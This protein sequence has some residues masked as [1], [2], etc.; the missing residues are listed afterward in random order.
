MKFTLKD[1]QSDA[2]SDVLR[3]LGKARRYFHLEE[4]RTAFS[5][6]AVTGAGK[7][8]MAAAVIESLFGGS[9]TFDFAPDP[10]AV[11]LWFS[12]DPSL[13]EQTRFRLLEAS[14]R[15][16]HSNLVAVQSTFNA[17][18]F[19]PG[20]VY[21]LNTQKLGKKSLLVRGHDEDEDARRLPAMSTAARPDLRSYTIWDTITNT[22]EDRNLTLYLVLDE[23]HRG[24]GTTNERE[25]STIVQRL[26]NG[27]GE[28]PPIPVVWGISATVER[29]DE[30]MKGV[31]GRATLPG[32]QVDSARVQQSGL[33]KDDIILDIPAEAG[34]FDTV[35]L[36]RATRKI[37][38][39]TDA[40]AKYA[41]E[42]GELDP[43]VPLLILQSPNTPSAE[44]LR[45]ALDLIFA[46]WEDLPP[47]AV[48]HVFGDHVT[49]HFGP[50]TVPYIAPERVQDAKHVRVL[51][52]KDAISTGWD[53]PRAEV[54]VSF[55]P[56]QDKTHIT[57]LLGRMVRA[58][59]A[60]RIPGDDRL[61]SV[62]C[63]LPFFDRKTATS[64]ATILMNSGNGEDGGG[65]GTGGGDGRR[66]LF[67]PVEMKPNPDLSKEVWECFDA[68]PSQS[69]PKRAAKPIKRLTALA[70]ALADDE[71]LP[72][73]GK[74]A[75]Q[76]LHAV[77]DGLAVRYENEVDA[78]TADVKTVEGE[79][80][81]GHLGG[82]VDY[83]AF[84]E[85]A[86]DRVIAD[87][88][89]A[90]E[91]V[92]SADV[93][94]TYA[95]HLAAAGNTDNDDEALRDA[96]VRVA[97][98]ALVPDIK[99]ALEAEA[100]KLASSWLAKYRVPIKGLSDERQAL[101]NELL[102]MSTEPQQVLLARPKVRQEETKERD[103]DGN[104][105]P[106][107]TRTKHLLCAEDG[108]FPVGSLN[109]W[110]LDVLGAELER[111]GTTAWYRNPARASQDSLA[112][113]YRDG[114]GAWKAMRPDFIFFSE[115]ASGEIG[116]SIVDPHGHHLGD[117]LPKLQGLAAFAA[118]F[119][120]AFLRID[121]IA[122][123]KGSLRVLDLTI[124]SV[125]KGVAEAAD[126]EALYSGSHAKD[127]H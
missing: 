34:R 103:K 12:D 32:V 44:M 49:M 94:L 81:R 38:E 41:A 43:V 120:G 107:P 64:V 1:Y 100:D 17:E 62:E 2:V 67:H 56:A 93:A 124:E 15:I 59:L 39:S 104:E 61:N 79:T 101:Y 71:L 88:Y 83:S 28:V 14:D 117:A 85:A 10:G 106:L 52:A 122:K 9:D 26:I 51:F 4:D 40:W 19:T 13:N 22:V 3:N 11:V 70:Q 123:V 98:L 45:R 86:D 90:A 114:K 105:T 66:V 54:L 112:V 55:R 99:Q 72:D 111:T 68:L 92:F 57:Q 102:A 37:V 127:Y 78:A 5:L 110:E 18:K 31:K 65:G 48:A 25:K 73:A 109:A 69:L 42:Q 16:G 46:E 118:K 6:T 84:S 30:A 50:W 121:A 33:L 108:T 77:L 63:L 23:A 20:K 89:R 80:V 82:T 87:A 53:C 7:T 36:K 125:R 95:E 35:L 21:L 47:G 119:D 116:A 97:A 60:R 29:F 27:H 58:P 91:R 113:S 8:V 96:H 76:Q 24:M 126:A 74:G 75:H 115:T